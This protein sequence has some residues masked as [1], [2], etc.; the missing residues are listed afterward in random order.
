MVLLRHKWIEI[1][2]WKIEHVLVSI[3]LK[4]YISS[5]SDQR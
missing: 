1:I 3:E 5:A 2:E 4:Q